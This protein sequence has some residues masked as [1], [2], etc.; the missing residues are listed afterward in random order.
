MG[1]DENDVSEN[2]VVVYIL[3][4]TEMVILGRVDDSSL[5]ASLYVGLWGKNTT[6][7]FETQA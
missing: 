1:K 4:P 5:A 3:I 2:A 6:V 7:L